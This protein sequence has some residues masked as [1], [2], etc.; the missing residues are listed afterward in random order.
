MKTKLFIIT[1]FIFLTLVNA[2][3]NEEVDTKPE[4]ESKVSL[5]LKSHSWKLDETF[6]LQ[7]SN[8][9]YPYMIPPCLRD[10]KLD[11]LANDYYIKNPG[12]I[13]CSGQQQKNDTLKWKLIN[14]NKQLE[15]VSKGLITIKDIQYLLNDSLIT[16][17]VTPLGDTQVYLYLKYK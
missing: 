3:K 8:V 9:L 2:C 6:W 5:E 1:G 12:T 10:D 7:K 13:L 16:S 4:P 14:N 17:E 15:I 11:Y